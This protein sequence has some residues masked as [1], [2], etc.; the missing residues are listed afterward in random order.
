ML[1]ARAKQG[2]TFRHQHHLRSVTAH[3]VRRAAKD[4]LDISDRNVDWGIDAVH[5]ASVAATAADRNSYRVISSC[6]MLAGGRR[7]HF[8]NVYFADSRP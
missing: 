4:Q 2:A 6:A 3:A 7:L 5:A 1:N 8:G